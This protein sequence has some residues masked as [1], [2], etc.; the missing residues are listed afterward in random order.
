[1]PLT[2]YVLFGMLKDEFSAALLKHIKQRRIYFLDTQE[3]DPQK[4][5][6]DNG[7]KKIKF[8]DKIKKCNK[9]EGVLLFDLIY[10]RNTATC[11]CIK[12]Y[13]PATIHMQLQAQNSDKCRP[14]L[15]ETVSD[16]NI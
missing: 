7:R 3:C 16:L 14:K 6:G 5:E 8:T 1:M 10:V 12:Q 9:T 2:R 15:E 11:N 4:N 13:V